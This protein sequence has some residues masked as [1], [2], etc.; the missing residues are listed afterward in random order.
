MFNDKFIGV[1]VKIEYFRN[2]IITV[3]RNGHPTRWV[4]S[5]VRNISQRNACIGQNAHR[6]NNARTSQ[7]VQRN[8]RQRSKANARNAARVSSR[9]VRAR[10]R[11]NEIQTAIAEQNVSPVAETSRAIRTRRRA[12]EKNQ[13]ENSHQPEY[14]RQAAALP[15]LIVIRIPNLRATDVKKHQQLKILCK[16]ILKWM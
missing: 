8:I 12:D 15:K 4:P 14:V 13:R 16:P 6:P 10:C 3:N 11:A 7:S 9:T 2:Y 5:R 1:P